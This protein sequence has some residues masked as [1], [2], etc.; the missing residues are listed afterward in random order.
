MPHEMKSLFFND[1]GSKP[2]AEYPRPQ[3]ERDS[4]LNLDGKWEYAIVPNSRV[5][6]GYQGTILVPFSPETLL[7][8]VQKTVHPD[9]ILYYRL[10]FD[11][12][13]SFLSEKTFLH[14]D[15]VDYACTVKLNNRIIG[16]HRSGFLPF[17]MDVSGAVSAGENCLEV[18]VTDPTDTGVGARGKQTLHPGG[19]WYTPQSGIWGPVWME[20]VPEDYIKD[21]T[22]VPDIDRGLVSVSV[23]S[24]APGFSVRVLDNGT[25]IAEGN[26]NGTVE[27]ALNS[28][29]LWSPE[30]PKLYDLEISVGDDTVKSYFGMRKFGVGPDEHGVRRLMLNN[31]PY[32]HNGVLDQGYWSDGKL[33][34]PT[35]EAMIYDIQMLK[36]MGF[37]MIRK[38]IKIEPLRWYYHCDR[39]GILV[40]QDMVNG[41][42][43]YNPLAT[44]ILP[45]LNIMVKDSHYKFFAREDKAGRDEYLEDTA[46]TVR[47][48][49]NTVSLAM[50]VP[51]NEGWGQFESD[52]VSEAIQKLDPTRTIDRTSGWH[53]QGHG[54]FVSKHIYFTPIRV[55]KDERC[56]LLSEFGGFS[57]LTPKHQ[58]TGLVF[59]YRMY[60]T[61]RA[62]QNGYRKIYEKRILPNIPKGLSACVFTQLSDVEGEINGLV[63][64]DRKVEKLDRSYVRDVND[65][66]KL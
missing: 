64:F 10:S 61:K 59:G 52:R 56:Y 18:E 12:P 39:L 53:D 29:E 62:L 36:D 42:G 60:P 19:I 37:T 9:D 40:W 24:K 48:L 3:L 32:F 45:F 25:C 17:A 16:V 20:S 33:T 57:K 35:D 11:V 2:R 31:K 4:Y 51:F 28:Y 65:K 22:I 41:G 7:S 21:L 15:A 46:S 13:D 6:A 49:K 47:L 8:G 38:H 44:G 23:E 43:K 58:Y 50:W 1:V 26:G 55:P 30:Q 5:R 14:F 34:A 63:T 66:C 27:L 54:D